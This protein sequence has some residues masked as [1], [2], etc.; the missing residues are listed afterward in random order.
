VKYFFSSILLVTNTVSTRV[1]ARY[2]AGT[3][4]Q[5]YSKTRANIGGVRQ[6]VLF[7]VFRYFDENGIE[8][9]IGAH[10]PHKKI[11]KNTF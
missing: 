10:W 2:R 11:R 6:N 9:L 1:P 7:Y 4:N 8:K 5:K 3:E